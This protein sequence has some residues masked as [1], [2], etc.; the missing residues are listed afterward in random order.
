MKAC[1]APDSSEF[2]A[3]ARSNSSQRVAAMKTSL[4]PITFFAAA[5]LALPSL[6]Q[7]KTTTPLND[8]ASPRG[9][10]AAP[11]S[12]VG[13]RGQMNKADMEKM[14]LTNLFLMLS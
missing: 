9:P 3:C 6:A 1:Q 14:M 10:A 11:A 4:S 5:L 2:D 13:S 12:P 7:E 8:T